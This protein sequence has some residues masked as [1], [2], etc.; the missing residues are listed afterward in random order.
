MTRRARFYLKTRKFLSYLLD[1]NFLV[2][3]FFLALSAAFWLFLAL[4]DEYEREFAVSLK[5]KNVPQN[6]VITTDLPKAFH[7]VLKDRGTQ[8]INYRYAGLPTINLDFRNYD[9]QSGHVTFPMTEITKVLSQ[10]LVGTTKIVSYK[11]D[12]LEY[13]Y[14]HGFNTN[15]PVRL[16]N[17]IKAEPFYGISSVRI[18]PDSVKV[19]APQEILDTMMQVVTRPLILD[20]LSESTTANVELNPVKGAKFVPSS[21]K[22]QI[23]VDQ[24]TEKTVAVPVRW[25]NFPASKTL[26]T[27]PAKVN[28][29]FQISMGMYRKI[30]ADDF[31]LV[32]NYE[33][34]LNQTD[35]K[36]HLALKTVPSGISH[37]RIVPNT[38][39]FL[40][41]DVAATEEN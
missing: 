27:F 34:L 16:N 19:Y 1:K 12:R 15:L 29:I 10:K 30:T 22:V 33:D 35:G 5:L 18:K 39:D 2:F 9:Q 23:A 7:V 32:V 25:V 6:V 28:I 41:E 36:V 13:F 26:R 38:V 20:N 21:V 3:L 40:I 37:V 24:M 4:D 11:P 17:K 8:L 14:N 31:V